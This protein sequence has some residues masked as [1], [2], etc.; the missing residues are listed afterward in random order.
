MPKKL[1]KSGPPAPPEES[2][3]EDMERVVD[4]VHHW[5]AATHGEDH[6]F[7]WVVQRFEDAK[8]G[9]YTAHLSINEQQYFLK[10]LENK[11]IGSA[12][13]TE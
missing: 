11:M 5:L 3:F 8:D 6:A 4:A 2:T 1:S 13:S 12:W 7:K 10:A 9:V